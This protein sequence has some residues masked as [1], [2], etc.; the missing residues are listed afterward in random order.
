MNR[1]EES[2]APRLLAFVHADQDDED[3]R[4]VFAVSQAAA[5]AE[6]CGAD[7]ILTDTIRRSPAFDRFAPGPVPVSATLEQGWYAHCASHTCGRRISYDDQSWA[8]PGADPNIAMEASEY[9]RRERD[10]K[11]WLDANPEPDEA[12][13]GAEWAVANRARIAHEEWREARSRALP[14]LE[15]PMLD[16]AA[17]RFDGPHVYCSLSCQRAEA[18]D[19]ARTDLR[20]ADAE[21]EAS[22]RWPGCTSYSSG[23]WPQIEPRVRFRPDGFEHDVDWH[24]AEDQPYV[25]PVDLP[26]WRSMI[27]DMEARSV[28]S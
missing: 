14:P 13:A 22:R 6:H 18:L 7:S 27:E 3:Q 10:E 28:K 19:I 25:M 2:R 24:V 20:H 4:I 23:R 21:D 17:L 9:A 15:V 16:K 12:P 1:T 8:G 11:R 26:A 5:R